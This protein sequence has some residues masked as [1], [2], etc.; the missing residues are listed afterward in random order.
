MKANCEICGQIVD[1]SVAGK[2]VNGGGKHWHGKCYET[3]E[4]LDRV[5]ACWEACVEWLKSIH[6]HQQ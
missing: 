3:Q 5:T 4:K 6:Q 2:T 1:Q